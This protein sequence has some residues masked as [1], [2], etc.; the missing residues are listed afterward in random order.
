M[1]QDFFGEYSNIISGISLGT[2]AL[3]FWRIMVF[4]KKDK[5]LLPFVNIAKTKAINLV[6]KVNYDA[7]M[8]IAK[9]VKIGELPEAWEQLKATI[10]KS[11]QKVDFII[12]VWLELGVLNE[13]PALLEEAQS[14]VDEQ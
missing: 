12:R 10:I 8:N 9:N 14:L 11:D 5:Y 1:V 3:V 4:F 13:L 6:G 2:V 7:F